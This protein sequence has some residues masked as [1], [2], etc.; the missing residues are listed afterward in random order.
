MSEAGFADW[1]GQV[2]SIIERA[3]RCGDR[4][5]VILDEATGQLEIEPAKAWVERVHA[6]A[7]RHGGIVIVVD[8][9]FNA[10]SRL[11]IDNLL[12]SPTT[13]SIA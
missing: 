13:C 10:G 11:S 7:R 9:R 8:H 3:I 2:I 6:S 1:Q 5:C 4:L 12:P